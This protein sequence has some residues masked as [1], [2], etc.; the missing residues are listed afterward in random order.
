M[1][2]ALK[3][4]RYS[5]VNLGHAGLGSSAYSHFTSPIRRYPDLIAHRGLLSVIDG[6]EERPDVHAVAGEAPQ[7]K[8]PL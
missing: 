4:A 5:E 3:P 2:R 1:L 8:Q 7:A 6:S